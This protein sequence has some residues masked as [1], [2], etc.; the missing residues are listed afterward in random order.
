MVFII[1]CIS[2]Q[3]TLL[4]I[5]PWHT[6]NRIDFF[7]IIFL[8]FWL[9]PRNFHSFYKSLS[10]LPKIR[11]LARSSSTSNNN[12]SNK[13][14]SRPLQS[15]AF[16]KP[17]WAGPWLAANFTRSERSASEVRN[18]ILGNWPTKFLDTVFGSH[19]FS[20]SFL[21]PKAPRVGDKCGRQV[22]NKC[23]FM[24]PKAPKL[25]GT[26]GKQQLQTRPRKQIRET[27][28][29]QRDAILANKAAIRNL[30]EHKLIKM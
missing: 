11:V 18:R 15:L 6:A 5:S 27:E 23:K 17:L 2:Y 7:Q 12:S 16:P 8:C 26:S 28:G 20:H 29:K 21:R 13:P 19:T 24:R 14:S 25:W 4:S 22:E 30:S 9:L 3:P 10:S 1:N